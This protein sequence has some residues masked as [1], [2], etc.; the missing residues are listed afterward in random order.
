MWLQLS[1]LHPPFWSLHYTDLRPHGIIRVSDSIAG[2]EREKGKRRRLDI[3]QGRSEKRGD[4]LEPPRD[5]VIHSINLRAPD[6]MFSVEEEMS[7]YGLPSRPPQSMVRPADTTSVHLCAKCSLL[8]R[9]RG[10][11]ELGN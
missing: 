8:G 2:T 9:S 4:A 10:S 11:R 7:I 3:T 6:L 5:P 1:S